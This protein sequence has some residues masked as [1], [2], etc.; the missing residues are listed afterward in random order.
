MSVALRLALERPA[1]VRD[2]VSIEGGVA[3]SAGTPGLRRALSLAGFLGHIGLQR[4][5][6]GKM[7]A[8]FR[9]SSGDPSWITDEVMAGYLAPLKGDYHGVIAAYKAMASATEPQA[10]EPRLPH[11]HCP[12]VLLVGGAPHDGAVGD[13]EI[14]VMHARVPAFTLVAVPGAGHWIQ[15]ERPQAVIEAVERAAR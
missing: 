2:L 9:A 1:Q 15:E 11:L 8:K 4:L 7:A 14:A 6:I 12:V 10:L 5:V 3:E 13:N